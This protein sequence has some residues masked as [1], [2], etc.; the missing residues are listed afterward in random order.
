[1]GLLLF[2]TRRWASALLHYTAEGI[3]TAAVLADVNNLVGLCFA[4]AFGD[5]FVF[6]AGTIMAGDG[7]GFRFGSGFGGRGYNRN[8]TVFAFRAGHD[9]GVARLNGFRVRNGFDG[10]ELQQFGGT[11]LLS[12]P[13]CWQQK[14]SG[15]RQSGE[16]AGQVFRVDRNNSSHI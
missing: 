12:R 14:H 4:V 2:H 7:A 5:V 11:F 15:N 1:M 10:G 9:D 6:A 3:F 13:K 8:P 16:A